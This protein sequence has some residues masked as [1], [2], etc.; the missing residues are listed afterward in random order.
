MTM[1][2]FWELLCWGNRT[3][4]IVYWWELCWCET[5]I[6][7]RWT[8]STTTKKSQCWGGF[9]IAHLLITLETDTP[10]A[11]WPFYPTLNWGRS[12][13][14]T[15][16]PKKTTPWLSFQW[17]TPLSV[18]CVIRTVTVWMSLTSSSRCCWK[19]ICSDGLNRW[20]C[21]FPSLKE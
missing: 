11:Q 3:P 15:S 21:P 17:S 5:R 6:N 10:V 16:P 18:G 9:F 20:A 7:T 2:L 1:W 4:S 14:C 8:I 13:I 12:L 19:K